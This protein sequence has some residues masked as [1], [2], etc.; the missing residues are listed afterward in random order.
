MSKDQ[1]MYSVKQIVD[2]EMALCETLNR[3]CYPTKV[4]GFFVLISRLGDGIIWYALMLSLPVLYG[5]PGLSSSLHMAMVG[6]INLGLYKLIKNITG[7]QR[8][9]VV[10]SNILLA[11]APL[12]QYSF[13]SGHT[14][15]AVAFSMVATAHHPELAWLLTPFVGL[16]GLSRIVLGLHYPSDVLAGALIGGTVAFFFPWQS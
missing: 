8:P 10:D 9:C 16:I 3:K 4:N 6:A 1:L 11:T 14:M 12:D 15:H 7:R 13:P 2:C 5:E